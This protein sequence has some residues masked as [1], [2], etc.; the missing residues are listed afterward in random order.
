MEKKEQQ[1]RTCQTP[2]GLN[3]NTCQMPTG[4]NNNT[5]I[6]TGFTSNSS[7]SPNELNAKSEKEKEYQEERKEFWKA[8]YIA[9]INKEHFRSFKF[10]HYADE[11]LEEFDKRFKTL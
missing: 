4:L 1:I 9:T 3:S 7:F 5:Y 6:N 10:F 8:V 2:T 11:A